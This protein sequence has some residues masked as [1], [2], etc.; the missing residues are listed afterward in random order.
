M[1]I[2][3]AHGPMAASQPQVAACHLVIDLH[4]PVVALEANAGH[5]QFL[6]LAAQELVSLRDRFLET[7]CQWIGLRE[8]R[9][10]KPWFFH[11]QI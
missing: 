9:N 11:Q 3:L 2:S 7:M 4:R 8:N 10:W 1:F 5:L 6:R